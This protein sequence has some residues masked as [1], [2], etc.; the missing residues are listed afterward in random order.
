[1]KCQSFPFAMIF[2]TVSLCTVLLF[3]PA[4]IGSAAE[5]AWTQQ[6]SNPSLVLKAVLNE[7]RIALRSATQE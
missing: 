1:M 6:R 4:S 7:R 5:A 3:L 2:A